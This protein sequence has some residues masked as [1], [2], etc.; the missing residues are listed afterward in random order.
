MTTSTQPKNFAVH[1]FHQNDSLLLQFIL[2]EYLLAQ[3][4]VID[5]Q[6]AFLKFQQLL[7]KS[8]PLSTKK[9]ELKQLIATTEL[10]SGSSFDTMR[11][12]SWG[13]ESSLL[14]KLNG[15]CALF[16]H[17]YESK[18]QTEQTLYRYVNQQ[19]LTCI[20]LHDTLHTFLDDSP[21]NWKIYM[22]EI[23]V[24]VDKIYKL[25]DRFKKLLPKV[26]SPYAKDE[27]VL[28]FIVRHHSDFD[29][30]FGLGY[31][32]SLLKKVSLKPIEELKKMISRR[33]NNRGF[34]QILP[35]ISEKFEAILKT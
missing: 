15:Y 2:S 17:Q 32:K 19:W 7:T 18:S 1:A 13:H 33:Y 31:T 26:I 20:Q 3:N 24:F 30:L 23:G 16:S 14:Y 12:F 5:L 21:K 25:G 28:F 4:Q 6:N 22:E 27:N 29:K 34:T 8:S 35:I 11:L 9:H 10:L